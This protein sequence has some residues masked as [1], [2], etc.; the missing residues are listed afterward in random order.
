M[1]NKELRLI[2]SALQYDTLGKWGDERSKDI[3]RLIPKIKKLLKE[4]ESEL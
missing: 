4:S 2:L 1:S 3:E